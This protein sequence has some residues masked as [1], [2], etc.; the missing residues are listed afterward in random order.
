MDDIRLRPATPA[1][2]EFLYDLHRRSL[3]DVI[4]A[5]WGPWDDAV[6][7]RFH[8]AWFHPET[9]EIVLVGGE[10]AGMVQA[11]AATADTFYISRLEIAPEVQGRGVGTALLHL[12]MDRARQAG[13]SVVEL[14]V[15]GLNRARELYERLGFQVIAEEPPKLRMR[16][17]GL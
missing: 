3:G 10:R 15:L 6:Q 1:D 5:T 16:R 7:R 17:G 4:E 11:A 14:H 9:I 2:D 8:Q 13:A 12:L